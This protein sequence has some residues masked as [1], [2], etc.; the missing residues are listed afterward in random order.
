LYSDWATNCPEYK[1]TA[2][3]IS[4]SNGPTEWQERYDAF[5]RNSR[6]IAPAE[7]AE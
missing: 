5:A 2:A 3:Q 7:A 1:V 6:R 4:P